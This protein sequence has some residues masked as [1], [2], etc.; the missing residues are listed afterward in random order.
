MISKFKPFQGPLQHVFKDPDTGMMYGPE[1]SKK[2]LLDRITLFRQQNNL[3]EI[4]FLSDVVE[5]YWCSLPENVGR[6]EPKELSRGLLAS[7]RGGI[8]VIKNYMYKSFVPQEVA[9]SRAK[10]CA[11]CKFNEMPVT[12]GVKHWLDLMAVNSV[13]DNRTPQ[14]SRLGTCTV[15]TC[16]LNMKVFYD[17]KVPATPDQVEKYK[18]V[19]CWQL[20][21]LE[22]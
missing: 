1:Q 21:I 16:P 15:C 13:G 12:A 7:I 6:C 19:N 8:A 11:S 9:E 2:T 3:P 18:S 5:N 22:N 10:Q 4:E 17:G 20:N 14:Y